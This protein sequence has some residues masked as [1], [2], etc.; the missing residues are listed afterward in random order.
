MENPGSF[1]DGVATDGSTSS[2]FYAS[3]KS[4]KLAERNISSRA[5]LAELYSENI[6]GKILRVAR[7][8]LGNNVRHFKPIAKIRA[9]L[10]I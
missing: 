4:P 3:P 6:V 8:K 2:I 10:L 7:E 9:K 1:L 5:Q